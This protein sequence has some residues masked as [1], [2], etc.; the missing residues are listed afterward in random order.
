MSFGFG[1]GDIVTCSRLAVKTYDALKSA[2]SEFADLRLE[3]GSLNSTL[4]ALAE[5]EKSPT[6]LIHLST[7]SRRA[8][9]RIIIENCKTGLEALQSIA[10]KYHSLAPSEK[11][12]IRELLR[13]AAKDKQGLREKLAIHT[14]S[15]NIFLTSLTH[16]SLGRLE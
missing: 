16:S 11:T 12:S 7:P 14:S 15:F 3:I 10:S 8:D 2:P 13:F 1:V 5:E 9:L 6:S 4:K